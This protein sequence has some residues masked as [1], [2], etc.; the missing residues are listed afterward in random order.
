MHLLRKLVILSAVNN[1]GKGVIK[2]EAIGDKVK[3]NITVFEPKGVEMRLGI[4]VGFSRLYEYE[5][6]NSNY[7]FELDNGMNLSERIE[8]IVCDNKSLEPLMVGCTDGKIVNI[9]KLINMF[10]QEHTR[11]L[12]HE[13]SEIIEVSIANEDKTVEKEKADYNNK[14]QD[15]TETVKDNI[16]SDNVD[17][18]KENTVNV[19][20]VIN[21]VKAEVKVQNNKDYKS[22]DNIAKE[23]TGEKIILEDIKFKKECI[24]DKIIDV[25]INPLKED[26]GK[27]EQ[28]NASEDFFIGIKPQ[29]DELFKC[30]PADKELMRSVPDSKWVRVNYEK[31]EYY[32]VGIMYNGKRATHICY[33]VPGI[34]TIRP[35]QKSEWLPLDYADPEGKG[36]WV[37]F[38]DA[39]TGKTLE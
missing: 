7:A 23:N 16:V 10:T 19:E 30:Y 20:K 13:T 37:I 1:V 27:E 39:I 8:C 6:N 38:Q 11:N 15:N 31:D 36:Y 17:K 4:R 26:K 18:V 35:K 29:L 32:V 28:D 3:G 22:K 12:F 24:T 9:D 34:Y 21:E 2:L 33:G 14:L 25:E 5:I